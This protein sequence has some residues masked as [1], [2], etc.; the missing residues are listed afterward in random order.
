MSNM[1]KSLKERQIEGEKKI[2][3]ELQK[4]SSMS[5]EAIARKCGFSRQ[6]AVRMIKD[7]EKRNVIWGY[8]AIIDEREQGLQKFILL[9]KRTNQPLKTEN[10]EKIAIGQFDNIYSELGIRIENNYYLHGEYDWAI[11][12]TAPDLR[13]ATKFSA[14][15]AANYPGV[16][17]KINLMQIL[18]SQRE[19]YIF[20]PHLSELSSLL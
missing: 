8:T 20:N 9:L 17:G 16:I 18:H 4:N 7:L 14:L 3:S 10:A 11:V 13:H 1:A 12:F 15:V 2:L 6:K 5:I 19:H